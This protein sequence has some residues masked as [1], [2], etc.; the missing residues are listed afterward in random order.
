MNSIMEAQILGALLE[1][2][3]SLQVMIMMPHLTNMVKKFP[4]WSIS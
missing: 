3:S 4:L 1:A 2:L